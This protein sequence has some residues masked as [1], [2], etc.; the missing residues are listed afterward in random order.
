MKRNEFVILFSL[1]IAVLT[2]CFISCD[3]NETPPPPAKDPHDAIKLYSSN[4]GVTWESHVISNT[5]DVYPD[6][7]FSITSTS[8]GVLL[9]SGYNND[10]YT[11]AIVAKSVDYGGNWTFEEIGVG[12]EYYKSVVYSNYSSSAVLIINKNFDFGSDG[13][14]QMVTSNNGTNWAETGEIPNLNGVSFS[15]NLTGVAVGDYGYIFKTTNGGYNWSQVQSPTGG[16]L[17]DIAFFGQTALAVGSLGRVIKSTDAGNTW[18]QL[19]IPFQ[20]TLR[21]VVLYSPDDAAAV[22]SGGIVLKTTNAGT[23]WTRIKGTSSNFLY[24]IAFDSYSGTIIAC[25]AGG[26]IMRSTNLGI[27]WISCNSGTIRNLYGI[28]FQVDCFIVGD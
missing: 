11:H 28:Y 26:T 7:L 15:D 24:D 12:N 25:G 20:N 13:S 21:G 4:A 1:L 6:V 22:G 10:S 23:N 27:D 2:V 16:E 14:N 5:S 9:A 3:S 19:T 17:Y 18:T 8:Q